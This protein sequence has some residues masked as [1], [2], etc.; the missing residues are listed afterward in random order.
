MSLVACPLDFNN[1]V[2]G[3]NVPDPVN[4]QDIATKIYVD[5]LFRTNSFVYFC[6][7]NAV[8]S[9]DQAL[10]RQNGTFT[11]SN[12]YIVPYQAVIYA[13]T[14]ENNPSDTGDSWDFEVE[15]N[16][17]I[18]VSITVPNTDHKVFDDTLKIGVSK[19]DEVVMYFRN[20]SGAVNRPGGAVYFT[21]SEDKSRRTYNF[22]SARN[23]TIS[24]DQALRRENG[25]FIS[26]NPYIIPYDSFLYSATAE[27][28]PSNVADTWDLDIE[29]NGTVVSTLN[30][31]AGDHKITNEN[32][33]VNVSQNDE[34]VLFF[35]NASG[36]IPNPGGAIFFKEL[37]IESVRA[38]S[39]TCARNA[40]ISS[41]QAL[42]RQNGTFISNN[43]YIVPFDSIIYAVSAENNPS[44]TVDTWDL[45]VEV[46]GVVV[47]TLPVPNT[48]HQVVSPLLSLNVI[49]GDEVV[50]FFRN[51]SGS[52]LNPGGAVY[53][54]KSS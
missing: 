4:P 51:A 1:Q 29:V 26:N 28:N 18:V 15:V 39:F 24:S 47:Y 23:A 19:G 53:L 2:T 43:P 22:L 5:R 3:I 7:R 52:I 33:N 27:N 48:D 17:R 31:P 13:V 8:I 44:N 45:E 21:K 12:P 9:T 10:R 35:R 37:N 20:A 41:D 14:A 36:S 32:L 25:T 38:Y 16:G 30:V 6:A 54:I 50:I 49:Q 40:S 34:V 42:R 46:N 11:S